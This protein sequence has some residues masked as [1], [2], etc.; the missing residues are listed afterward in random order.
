MSRDLLRVLAKTFVFTF[1]LIFLCF[2]IRIAFVVYVGH[3]H[4]VLYEEG[5]SFI[6]LLPQIGLMF[7]NGALFDYRGVA[8]FAILYFVL[9]IFG[10]LLKSLCPPPYFKFSFLNVYAYIVFALFLF[11]SIAN[12]TYYTIYKDVFNIVLLGIFFDD[13]QAILE[14]GLSGKYFLSVKILCF[15]VAIWLCIKIYNLALSKISIPPLLQKKAVIFDLLLFSLFA[16][17]MLCFINSSFSLDNKSLDRDLTPPSNIF[18]QKIT[19]SPFRSLYQVY[20]GYKSGSKATFSSFTDKSPSQ[21][22]YDFFELSEPVELEEA[23]KQS[24]LNPSDLPSVDHVFY[25]VAESLG[26]Y[27]FDSKYDEI[28]L[29]SGIKSLIDN[30]K[31][32]RVK[33]F[34][35]SARATV[36]SMESQIGGIYYTGIRL[37]L[38]ST[39]L[40]ALPT[41]PAENFKRSGF[42]TYYYYGG[43]E[44][45]QNL[46]NFAQSQGFD[47]SFGV[48]KMEP[49]AKAMSYPIPYRNIWGVW[50][51]ILFDFV[52]HNVKTAKSPTFNMI[53][54][55]TFHGPYD[56]PWEYI[57]G[58]GVE[59]KI[60]EDFVKHKAPEWNSLELAT[61]WW[62]DKQIEKFVKKMSKRYPRSLFVITGDHSIPAFSKNF[63]ALKEVAMVLYAPNLELKKLTDVGDHLD[64]SATLLALTTPKNFKFFSF[65][66]PLFSFKQDSFSL[67][68]K[69]LI[70]FEVSGDSK[71]I[72]AENGN[73]IDLRGGGLKPI[74]KSGEAQ[75]YLQRLKDGQALS[76]YL[77][78]N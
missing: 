65:G 3:F 64:I 38:K 53:L 26:N 15:L 41:A 40:K 12:F 70:G 11:V 27:V 37:S 21:A 57:E 32:F 30:K 55:T 61:L 49:F 43:S 72:Y 20:K 9:G 50:D 16:I 39:G 75:Y 28:G 48:G 22:I 60:F 47:K 58:I 52:A 36:W 44:T 74:L 6:S 66:K 35:E 77:F 76:W 78:A 1:L 59:R 2:L 46:G 13:Q 17:L 73:M 62:V 34:F 25:I 45:W 63:Q 68:D 33:S 69:K 19:P 14:D 29:V 42:A 8:V 23:L 31:G 7:Y 10:L 51:N 5:E 54:T 67:K 56:L 24:S 71:K 18:L 4:G